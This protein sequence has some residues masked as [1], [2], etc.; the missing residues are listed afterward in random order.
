MTRRKQSRSIE[1]RAVEIEIV[2]LRGGRFEIWVFVKGRLELSREAQREIESHARERRKLT[3]Q[4]VSADAGPYGFTLRLP[5]WD[6]ADWA[7]F[8]KELLSRR[9]VLVQKGSDE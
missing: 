2:P 7:E 4:K 5:I 9:D 1:H 3:G 8:F 6:E